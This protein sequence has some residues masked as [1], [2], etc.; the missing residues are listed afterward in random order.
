MVGVPATLFLYFP[1][2]MKREIGALAWG[3]LASIFALIY[4]TIIM[5]V[6]APAYYKQNAEA[7]TTEKFV[8]KFDWNFFTACSCTFFAYTC[9]V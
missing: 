7:P 8:Y 9:Q 4:V 2:S 1:L 3:G 5:T 6:E